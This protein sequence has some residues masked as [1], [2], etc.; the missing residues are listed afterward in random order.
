MKAVLVLIVLTTVGWGIDGGGGMIY[1]LLFLIIMFFGALAFS[2]GTDVIL[3]L[4]FRET[5]RYYEMIAL[6][7]V[8]LIVTFIFSLKLGKEILHQ[9]N[10]IIFT[11]I[12]CGV[13]VPFV[14]LLV[15][16]NNNERVG[17]LNAFLIVLLSS[18]IIA[19]FG[20]LPFIL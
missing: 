19:I 1:A 12:M 10:P 20:G 8:I 13:L 14:A 3:S 7:F 11:L 15:R 16:D 2:I 17:F 5:I 6:Y 9:N 18:M 4:N